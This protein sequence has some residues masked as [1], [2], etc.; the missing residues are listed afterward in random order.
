[1]KFEIPEQLPQREEFLLLF[2]R[3][4]FPEETKMTGVA[5]SKDCDAAA[6]DLGLYNEL[7]EDSRLFRLMYELGL[8]D[9][10]LLGGSDAMSMIEERKYTNYTDCISRFCNVDGSLRNWVGDGAKRNAKITKGA[11]H[12]A[13]FFTYLLLEKAE[14]EAKK[15]VF[16]SCLRSVGVTDFLDAEKERLFR[17]DWN[18]IEGEGMLFD[19]FSRE[20]IRFQRMN[21]C[22]IILLGV[23]AL[24]V[25]E[26][27]GT[28]PK[29]GD[30]D[31]IQNLHDLIQR[32]LSQ[33][34]K[35][36]EAL[37]SAEQTLFAQ[38]RI[39]EPRSIT[40]RRQ[41]RLQ[42]IFVMP[43]IKRKGDKNGEKVLPFSLL[44]D[45]RKSIRCMIEAK[46]GMG[47][48]VL[49]QMATVC[50][51]H[52]RSG[53]EDGDPAR[54]NPVRT[55][56]DAPDDLYVISVPARMFSFCYGNPRYKA[57]TDDFLSLFFN[58]MW[59]LCGINFFKKDEEGVEDSSPRDFRFTEGMQSFLREMARKGRLLLI[60]DS[61]DEISSGEM[62]DAYLQAMSAFR[63]QYCSFHEAG[64]VGAHVILC[65][66]EMSPETMDE[67]MMRMGIREENVFEI[68]PLE[69][70]ERHDLVM[71]WNRFVGDR[72]AEEAKEILSEIEQ[73]HF[74]RDY[75]KNPYMLSVVYFNF[76][77]KLS[78]V[79]KRYIDYLVN[80]MLSHNRNAD[81]A[82]NEVLRYIVQ[83][84]Q[85]IARETVI[86]G[87]PHFSRQK[88][89]KYLAERIDR[90]DLTERE[91]RANID[92]L[93]Q[94]FVTEVGLIV[95]AD[96]ADKD[97]QFINDQI[98]YELAAKSIRDRL[99]DYE[100]NDQNLDE[101]LVSV[102][103]VWE[104][105]G[106][107]VPLLC[108]TDLENELAERLVFDLA[109]HEF[110]DDKEERVLLEAMLDLLLNRYGSSIVTFSDPDVREERHF[111]R[112][113][114]VL[115]MRVLTSRNFAPTEEER[116]ALPASPAWQSN[117]A[118]F[119]DSLADTLKKNFSH[120][121]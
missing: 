48:S 4:I 107:L 23:T 8:Q 60:L 63:E 115:L 20:P 70:R 104:Y 27:L 24:A 67:L 113:Q 111:R 103:S 34:Q 85:E 78:D 96:G 1:M 12:A 15:S 116:G 38:N 16:E 110:R 114:R 102:R 82:V 43:I 29:P 77:H 37:N 39:F 92:K 26:M 68:L 106:F 120:E 83:I 3:A 25:F 71:N 31:R 28:Y 14:D 118:W 94:I 76:E 99:E 51:L 108:I 73:N 97:Y 119:S 88:L 57:W 65:T 45:A 98:R 74:Y 49:M 93:H 58:C 21:N 36:S 18:E 87:K 117:R 64:E 101:L 17:F 13:V 105:V 6:L 40:T 90:K 46:T 62:R 52:S 5:F 2:L 22:A 66:R 19:K 53:E 42:D 86:T 11:F 7:T 30:Y 84:L 79:T 50:M 121:N 109:M 54:Q 41:P 80:R 61:F 44:R 100:S 35:M 10:R 72:T 9:K 47:K 95:P 55:L 32:S 89:E 75:S 91:V 112:A 81:F 59:R 56:L 69:E 33:E